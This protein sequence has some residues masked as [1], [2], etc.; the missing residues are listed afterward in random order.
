MAGFLA[1]FGV[2]RKRVAVFEQ[3]A[4]R[5][6][7]SGDGRI[8]MYWPGTLVWEQKSAGKSLEDAENQALDYLYDL[9][10]NESPTRA[11]VGERQLSVSAS[12]KHL[13]WS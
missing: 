10:R 6:S 12:D 13:P 4:R 1:I 7:T 11:S 2:E 8:D 3:H 5:T 9:A